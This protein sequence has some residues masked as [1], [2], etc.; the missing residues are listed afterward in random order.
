MSQFSPGFKRG[1]SA[2]FGQPI[3][4]SVSRRSF[5]GVGVILGA[6]VGGKEGVLAASLRE[7]RLSRA[8]PLCEA[9]GGLVLFFFHSSGRTSPYFFG[10]EYSLVW[11]LCSVSLI[12]LGKSYGGSVGFYDVL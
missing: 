4:Q 3:R 5:S 11:H 12:L 8:V 6:G 1:V 10:G 7:P 9:G 2:G